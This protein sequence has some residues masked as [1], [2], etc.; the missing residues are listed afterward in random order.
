MIDKATLTTIKSPQMSMYKKAFTSQET[1]GIES[2][3]P[4]H[5]E[6]LFIIDKDTKSKSVTKY[7]P[8][9][10]EK[11]ISTGAIESVKNFAL[12]KSFR[13]FFITSLTKVV[14]NFL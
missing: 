7:T 14:I 12:K 6:E 4:N 3:Q 10:I 1:P 9:T 8:N 2:I 11:T 5:D 13:D